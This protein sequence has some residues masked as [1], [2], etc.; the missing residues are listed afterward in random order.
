MSFSYHCVL[1]TNIRNNFEKSKFNLV[2]I[3]L[4]MMANEKETLKSKSHYILALLAIGNF[5]S[6]YLVLTE[7]GIP[8]F[9]YGKFGLG[10]IVIVVCTL[11]ATAFNS[12][13]S[14]IALYKSLMDI[15]K[16]T[17]DIDPVYSAIKRF[18]EKKEKKSEKKKK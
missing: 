8:F 5:F 17:L 2:K 13:I 7:L 18:L 3:Y 9:Q 15:Y 10:S 6:F 16:K 11:F 4:L 1:T 12:V 14:G